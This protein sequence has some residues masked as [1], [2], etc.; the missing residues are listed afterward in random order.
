MTFMRQFVMLSLYHQFSSRKCRVMTIMVTIEMR[1]YKQVYITRLQAKLSQLFY[2]T[3]LHAWHWQT[4]REL[5]ILR[6]TAINQNIGA[7]AHLYQITNKGKISFW[8]SRY[9]HKIK[10]LR[11]SAFWNHKIS[12]LI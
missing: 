11:N 12:F 5:H 8:N 1:T 6:K 2:Y 9:P 4:R 3:L 7:I 10:S